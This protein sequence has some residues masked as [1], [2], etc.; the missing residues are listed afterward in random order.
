MVILKKIK[1]STLM[2]TLVASVLIIIVF[3][4]AS[5]ILN[6]MFSNAITSNTR[7]IETHLNELDY[8]YKTDKLLLPYNNTFNDWTVSID[9]FKDNEQLKVA[10]EATQ[11][12][13]KKT[14]IRTTIE[15]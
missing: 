1:G 11:T 12:Q 15:N 6:T 5:L 3:M 2:E 8:L 14:I 13:T 7:A 4:V 9:T 10:F